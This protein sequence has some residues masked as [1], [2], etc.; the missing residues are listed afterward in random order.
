MVGDRDINAARR[1]FRRFGRV[2]ILGE[3]D[4]ARV[5][6]KRLGKGIGIGFLLSGEGAGRGL[7]GTSQMKQVS[8]RSVAAACAFTA[9][10]C[11]GLAPAAH[12]GDPAEVAQVGTIG[13]TSGVSLE[14]PPVATGRP[15]VFQKPGR[16]EDAMIV[17]DW[18]IYP[19]AFGGFI[20]DSNV[21]QSPSAK[22]SPGIRLAPA[23]LVQNDNDIFNTTFYGSGDF[24][25]YF[26]NIPNYGTIISARAGGT[27]T[28]K[29]LPDVIIN[30]QADYTRQMDLFSTL[31]TDQ[32]V[33]PLNPTGIGLA[34]TA[35]PQSYN[36]FTGAASAQKNFSQAFA[37][38]G[39]SV[40]DIVYD[41]GSG[42]VAPSPNGV[43][44]TGML[45][46]GYW[47][48]PAL[49]GYAEGSLDSRNYD[50]SSLSSSGYR[51]VGG[52]G[53]D[54]IGLMK[55]EVYFGYQAENFNGSGI[56]TV[57]SPVYGVRG[58]YYPL[59]ELTINLSV[60]QS[61]GVSLLA[62][63]GGTPGSS[64]KV[65]TYLVNA[66]YA[67]AQEWSANGRAGYITTD[68]GGGS[69]RRDNS[70]TV[71]GTVTY[72]LFRNVGLTLDYQ[73]LKLASNVPNQGFTRDVAT[74]GL[75]WKY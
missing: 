58:Y 41:Q 61:L 13:G 19:S 68:Y 42:G 4:A 7:G 56:S 10:L 48:F 66:N 31:G 27:E 23:F 52:F 1:S 35:N 64:T 49:Y 8:W 75:T 62:P 29:P 57:Q 14:A 44:Y 5:L 55:G 25:D 20:Y 2:A 59:P 63:T 50:T 43:T 70:W 11:Y 6:W 47:I 71:G 51:V 12:A 72:E 46:G 54:Q 45:R 33:A 18:L 32:S 39:G 38:I 36:Q 24:R 26:R 65:R 28:Y 69:N 53:T 67:L 16:A 22:S 15:D 21:S 37:T 9:L 17:G 40:V 73:H 34:P 3:G 74:V 60:D 30:G